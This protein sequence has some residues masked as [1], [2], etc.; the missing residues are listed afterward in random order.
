M[1]VLSEPKL[2][3]AILTILI[4][5]GFYNLC[6]L[7]GHKVFDPFIFSMS[8]LFYTTWRYSVSTTCISEIT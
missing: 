5:Q 6:V 3:G 4:I 1:M 8:V 7:V 2:V